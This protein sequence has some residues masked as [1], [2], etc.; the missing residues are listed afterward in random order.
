MKELKTLIDISP[1]DL[2]A[3]IAKILAESLTM[4]LAVFK[5]RRVGERTTVPGDVLRRQLQTLWFWRHSN[6]P[7]WQPPHHELL[8]ERDK[9][10][11]L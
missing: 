1:S 5:L 10:T 3:Y 7:V 2:S 9:A 6:L 4:T 8:T 11:T